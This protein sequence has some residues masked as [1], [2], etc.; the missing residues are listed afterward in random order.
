MCSTAAPPD[1]HMHASMPPT[2]QRWV[3]GEQWLVARSDISKSLR[4][5]GK[6]AQATGAPSP[7]PLA[8]APSDGAQAFLTHKRA[9]EIEPA[10][11]LARDARGTIDADLPPDVADDTLRFY[12]TAA[13]SPLLVAT[14]TSLVATDARESRRCACALGGDALEFALMLAAV[15]R[16]VSAAPHG[17]AVPSDD[18]AD[19]TQ[20]APRSEPPR[21]LLLL[22]TSGPLTDARVRA[23][24]QERLAEATVRTFHLGTD[25]AAIARLASA[26][27]VASLQSLGTPPADAATRAQLL[28][29]LR[30][31]DAH[32]CAGLRAALGG[33]ADV[34][35]ALVGRVV[36][37]FFEVLWAGGGAASKLVLTTHALEAAGDARA[38]APLAL[39]RMAGPPLAPSVH[40]DGGLPLRTLTLHPRRQRAHRRE[41]S[42][43]FV[44]RQAVVQLPAALAPEALAAEVER[45]ASALE[46]PALAAI[47][48]G[49]PIYNVS[50][51]KG[52]ARATSTA[53]ALSPQALPARGRAASAGPQPD[54]DADA[55]MP[56]VLERS[57]AIS[58][59]RSAAPSHSL[60]TRRPAFVNGG[61]LSESAVLF[62]LAHGCLPGGELVPALAVLSVVDKHR[63]QAAAAQPGAQVGGLMPEDVD[64]ILA[65]F[66][67]SGA[68]ARRIVEDLGTWRRLR[69]FRLSTARDSRVHVTAAHA[70]AFRA[71]FRRLLGYVLV[72]LCC[73]AWLAFALPLLPHCRRSALLS[74]LRR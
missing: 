36:V 9:W 48:P 28:R 61:A 57:A 56:A 70:D 8:P 25:A 44:G 59:W 71:R 21:A 15:E 20:G 34:P 38:A 23:L 26:V 1:E 50:R 40:V 58:D 31:P 64:S 11:A 32:G 10:G 55:A 6:T 30:R 43:F 49:I 68:R 41:L 12:L 74:A 13:S 19:G 62:E 7:Q 5:K 18:A 24:L 3:I 33:V 65:G 51:I 52:V 29:E 73:G 4:A 14:D 16:L 35:A 46:A 37:A 42:E 63:R 39:V 47:A 27:G 54:A 72:C 67:G 2:M 45:M 60:R 53:G 22:R 66:V 69:P 17:R